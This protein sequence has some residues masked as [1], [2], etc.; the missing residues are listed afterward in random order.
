MAETKDDKY[1]EI[2]AD[3]RDELIELLGEYKIDP[4]KAREIAVAAAERTRQRWAGLNIYVPKGQE[5]QT[6]LRDLEIYRKYNGRNKLEL[7]RE[8]Q[9]S[10]QWF[11]RI[12]ARVRA[13]KI[14]E[15]QLRLF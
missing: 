7:C 5:W 14:A 8:Y 3:L 10:E 9:I 1:P 4:E 11:Y 6:R 15:K 13:E 12:M 2:L